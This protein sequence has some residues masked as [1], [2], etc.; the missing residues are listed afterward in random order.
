MYKFWGKDEINLIKKLYL[1]DGLSCEELYLIYKKEFDRTK[2]S[3]WLKIKRLKLKHTKDQTKEIKS[4]GR[5]GDKNGM[6]NKLSPLKGLT[7]EN[8]DIIKEG[9]LKLSIKRKEMFREGKLLRME[10]SKNPMYGKKSWNN[11]LTKFNTESIFN[12][13]L[14]S[15]ITIKKNW[16]K[17]TEEEKQI[18][19]DRLQKSMIQKKKMNKI[20]NK[21]KNLLEDN[22]INFIPNK[23]INGFYV[24]FFLIDFNLVIECDGDF[25]HANPKFYE[26]KN[27]HLIQI[28]NKERDERK[29][30]M[31]N[32]NSI[33]FLRFWEYDIHNNFNTVKS[34]ILI[35]TTI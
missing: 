26:N 13:S 15:S 2:E 16:L 25:W 30:K 18:I 29:N 9:A 23:Y 5:V 28:K 7:K 20:E 24:D 12:G 21:I 33:D 3:V 22:D 34:I 1:D 4:R 14:K 35:K 11:G 6:F 17:K 10:G 31:L 8:S 32:D 27:L 19:V